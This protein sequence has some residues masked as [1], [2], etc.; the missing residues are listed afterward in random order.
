MEISESLPHSWARGLRKHSAGVCGNYLLVTFKSGERFLPVQAS[1]RHQG[2]QSSVSLVP[3]QPTGQKPDPQPFPDTYF[4][5]GLGAFTRPQPASG[6]RKDREHQLWS[7]T[8]LSLR[9]GLHLIVV[10][11]LH[12][13]EVKTISFLTCNFSPSVSSH[14]ICPFQSNQFT[15]LMFCLEM[16]SKSTTSGDRFLS[17]GPRTTVHLSSTMQMP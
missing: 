14:P 10:Q 11:Q 4:P 9:P 17:L 12:R 7:G 6:S 5:P 16:L 8:G 3:V 13:L 1:Q 15:L 2:H